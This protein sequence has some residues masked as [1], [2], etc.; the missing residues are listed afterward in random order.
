[1]QKDEFKI[2]TAHHVMTLPKLTEYKHWKLNQTQIP[3]GNSE[4]DILDL[5]L[6][7]TEVSGT[8]SNQH[9]MISL[10]FIYNLHF[11]GIMK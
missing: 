6:T 5:P 3:V 9:R 1:M 2:D 8:I 4:S 11:S 7:T 10:C